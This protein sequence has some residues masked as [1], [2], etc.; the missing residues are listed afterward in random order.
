MQPGTWVYERRYEIGKVVLALGALLVTAP[1]LV[2]AGS[3]GWQNGVLFAVAD[4]ATGFLPGNVDVPVVIF[5]GIVAGW[6]LLFALDATKRIQVLA[7]TPVLILVLV[8]LGRLDHIVDAMAREPLYFLATFAVTIVVMLVA[9]SNIYLGARFSPSTFVQELRLVHFPAASRAL[10][11]VL[12]TVIVIVTVQY[13][14]MDGADN[15]PSIPLVVASA[16]VAIP[17]LAVFIQYRSQTD[18]VTLTPGGVV[19]NDA[20]CTLL[21][22]LWDSTPSPPRASDGYSERTIDNIRQEARQNPTFTDPVRFR[23]LPSSALRRIVEV[24]LVDHQISDLVHAGLTGSEHQ[25]S[26]S[27]RLRRK[28]Q[29]LTWAMWL[30]LPQTPANSIVAA[31]DAVTAVRAADIV[32][33]V[34]PFPAESDGADRYVEIEQAAG[35]L[36]VIEEGTTEDGNVRPELKGLNAKLVITH[37]NRSEHDDGGNFDMQVCS[38][39][40]DALGGT[41]TDEY[42]MR[43]DEQLRMDQGSN[44]QHVAVHHVTKVYPVAGD[45]PEARGFDEILEDLSE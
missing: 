35:L 32:V 29:E 27:A 23:Y 2:R 19:G 12:T 18:I 5:A 30:L 37:A 39:L 7:L 17:S 21:E 9:T 43:I 33:I 25:E 16:L 20:K 42:Q 31:N 11:V 24:N 22:G 45:P 10:F 34:V 28:I 15:G 41:I 13:P 38:Q 4:G 40:L 1:T 26:T 6:L 44:V 3:I 36:R 8:E 14:F